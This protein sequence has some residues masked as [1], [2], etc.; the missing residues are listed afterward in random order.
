MHCCNLL[1]IK[2]FIGNEVWNQSL[3]LLIQMGNDWYHAGEIRSLVISS[4]LK[5]DLDFPFLTDLFDPFYCL[6]CLP[7]CLFLLLGMWWIFMNTNGE[8][9]CFLF[10]HPVWLDLLKRFIWMAAISDGLWWACEIVFLQAGPAE[11]VQSC[12]KKWN[13]W[14]D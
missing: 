2:W 7:A 14:G 1:L 4:Q 8:L 11:W 3:V 10:L 6:P 5:K 12:L 9:F 13:S